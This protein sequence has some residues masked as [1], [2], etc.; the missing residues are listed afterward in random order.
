MATASVTLYTSTTN[1][2]KSVAVA[3]GTAGSDNTVPEEAAEVLYR[4]D[5]LVK[6]TEELGA[7]LAAEY[8]VRTA[9]PLCCDARERCLS[10]NTCTVNICQRDI[11]LSLAL[12]FFTLPRISEV[13]RSTKRT[14]N[15]HAATAPPPPP[16]RTSGRW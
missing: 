11:E 14:P 13:Q 4:R 1:D 10:R 6:R 8:R 16:P 2:A 5:E 12:F 7:Q 15:A 3:T 9:R